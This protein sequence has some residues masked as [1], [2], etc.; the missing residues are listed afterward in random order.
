MKSKKALYSLKDKKA[1]LVV[2]KKI[3]LS[4]LIYLSLLFQIFFVMLSYGNIC[5]IFG[6][7]CPKCKYTNFIR[8][9]EPCFDKDFILGR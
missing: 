3:I 7:T 1:V 2:C 4:R 9:F 5:A 6:S 8:D